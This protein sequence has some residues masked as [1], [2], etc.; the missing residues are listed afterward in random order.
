MD[1]LGCWSAMFSGRWA[2]TLSLPSSRTVAFLQTQENSSALFTRC[3]HG[4][5][6]PGFSNRLILLSSLKNTR[7]EPGSFST[8]KCH[9]VTNKNTKE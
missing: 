3:R 1:L 4:V 6:S 2:S 9:T 8:L 5:E 7:S